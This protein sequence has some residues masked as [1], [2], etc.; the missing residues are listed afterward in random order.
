MRYP[1]KVTPAK[2][3]A[4]RAG[5]RLELPLALFLLLKVILFA[6]LALNSRYTMD[7]YTQASYALKIPEGFYRGID[8]IKTVLYVYVF[9]VAHR[10]SDS[11]VGLMICARLEGALLAL[12]TAALT[13]GVS[14]RLGR[15]VLEA[16]FAV[17]T[18]FSFSNFMER[19]FNVRSDT[20]AVFFAMA[21]FFAATGT[22]AA[23]GAFLAGVLAGAAFLSTQKAV[24]ALVALAAGIV[25]SETT[26][27][28][29]RRSV[30]RAAAFALG[31]SAALLA[32]AGW[33][34]GRDFVG[35]IRMV[36]ESPLRFAPLGNNP[37]YADIGRFVRQTLERNPVPYTLCALGLLAVAGTWREQSPRV[38]LAAT[39]TLVVGFLV[40]R[41]NQPWPYAFVMALP[42]LSL[43][44]SE[45][46]RFAASRAGVS[47]GSL[48][49]V[50]LSLLAMSI[51]RN[52]E[53][54]RIDNRAQNEVTAVAESLLGPNDRYFD[55]V[56]MVPTR[57]MSAFVSWEAMILARVRENA[58][59]GDVRE[60]EETFE[61]RP[62]LWIDNYR[63][64]AAREPLRPFL[65]PSY[66][67]VHR[68]VLLSG[69]ALPVSGEVSFENRWPGSYRLWDRDGRP[70][71]GLFRVDG[72]EV[73]G[74]VHLDA[75]PH[76]IGR[77]PS[78]AVEPRW[79][80]PAVASLPGS[81]PPPAPPYDLFASVYE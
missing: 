13:Y 46:L 67:R 25:A 34:G 81:L 39:S 55:A 49:A 7:E 35:V 19:A 17:A 71:A 26:R 11:A 69:A 65:E 41:H 6:G 78:P 80:L 9:D 31:A 48:T 61:G 42:F 27:A 68:N 62:K 53:Y 4:G 12:A 16:L 5:L 75:G 14:R 74:T 21:A 45:A 23:G 30:G 63:V 36:F 64:D 77:V 66:V 47:A 57:Q 44:A 1:S 56:G 37:H 60:I 70:V 59:H 52:L 24:Y 43:W 15:S 18:L 50:A 32:Y 3:G 58:A 76:R 51:P 29:L 20:V 2:D 28:G 38:R 22:S 10:L 54:F 79:L 40:F 8:P 73:S 72:M 33:F